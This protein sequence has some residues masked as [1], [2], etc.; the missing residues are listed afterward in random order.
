LPIGDHKY[1]GGMGWYGGYPDH[2]EGTYM[3]TIPEIGE[4]IHA[5]W[6]QEDA[7]ATQ[8]FIQRSLDGLSGLLASRE[9]AGATFDPGLVR[10]GSFS[11][12]DVDAQN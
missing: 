3:A 2:S 8:Q 4:R 6:A 7:R 5:L 11:R 9:Y 10:L 1:T 12:P